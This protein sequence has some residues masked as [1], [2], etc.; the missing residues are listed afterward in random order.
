MNLNPEYFNQFVQANI[1][2]RLL[3]INVVSFLETILVNETKKY[4]ELQQAKKNRQ[5]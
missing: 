2:S 3:T 5:A 4:C 1:T